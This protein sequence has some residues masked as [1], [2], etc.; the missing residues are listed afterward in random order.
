MALLNWFQIAARDLPW[1]HTRDPYAIWISEV[2]LQQTQVATVIP[3][4]QRWMQAFPD[5]QE[6]ASAS[7]TKVLKHWEGLGYYSRARNLQMA[8]RQIVVDHNGTF[9]RNRSQMMQ[10]KGI[11]PYTAGAV[12]SIAFNQ[13]APIVDG[14]VGRVLSRVHAVAGNPTQSEVRNT[15]WALASV[16]VEK[17]HAMGQE[18]PGLYRESCSQLNQALM[19]LG[20]LVCS[21]TQPQCTECPLAQGCLAYRRQQTHLFPEK[22]KRTKSTSRWF[23][24]LIIQQRSQWLLHQRPATGVNGGLWEF[25][26]WEVDESTFQQGADELVKR[27]PVLKSHTLVPITK[28]QHAITRYRMTQAVYRWPE[29]VAPPQEWQD[30]QG[31]LTWFD[32]SALPS[33]PLTGPHRK[34]CEQLLKM[35][36]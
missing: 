15:L 26:N 13:A 24:T 30:A 7:E 25:P 2:M 20:A 12:A 31:T 6:L 34:L 28:L 8:A 3:Y 9:P 4:W 22:S 16:W 5:I 14:N 35:D 29:N 21:P 27:F 19:E 10:L 33:I 18:N 1:R 23:I 11:G 32:S 36:R 17:A